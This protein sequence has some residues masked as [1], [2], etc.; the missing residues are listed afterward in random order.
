[1][2]WTLVLP[3]PHPPVLPPPLPRGLSRVPTRP[4][5]IRSLSPE[6]VF[7]PVA[8][9]PFQY[10]PQHHPQGMLN[11]ARFTIPVDASTSPSMGSVR[12]GPV[13]VERTPTTSRSAH[14]VSPYSRHPPASVTLP[15][16]PPPKKKRKCADAEQL[17]VLNE[18]Y[19]RTAFPSTEERQDLALRL[20]M[21]PRSVQIWY[22]SY[23]LHHRLS[24]ISPLGFKIGVRQCVTLTASQ[25]QVEDPDRTI[26]RAPT[27]VDHP[28]PHPSH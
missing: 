18:V 16:H 21:S 5:R 19:A 9:Y 8:S 23:F 27:K 26:C 10:P 22:A 11:E 2:R 24:L 7:S 25:A 20:G 6:T 4:T 28:I 17:R 12:R 1:M 14:T 13:S 3:L 15:D